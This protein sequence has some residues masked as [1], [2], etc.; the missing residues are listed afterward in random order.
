MS[1]V[2]KNTRRSAGPLERPKVATSIHLAALER[3]CEDSVNLVRK[4]LPAF[5][6]DGREFR[7]PRYLFVGPKG[8]GEPIRVGIFAGVHGDE[9]EGT[10]ALSEF[11]LALERSPSLA[12][13]FFLFLYPIVNP[14][15]FEQRTRHT[16]E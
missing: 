15:G 14:S 3:A 13:D 2:I 1:I 4:P 11:V 10:F 8:G 9:P 6:V 5:Q 16:T 12:R 7:I